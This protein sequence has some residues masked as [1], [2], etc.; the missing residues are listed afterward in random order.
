MYICIGRLAGAVLSGLIFLSLFIHA[1]LYINIHIDMFVLCILLCE[2]LCFVATGTGT[3]DGLP[4]AGE[5]E[6][7]VYKFA[8]LRCDWNWNL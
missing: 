3:C 6:A 4:S 1:C 7:S 5:R 8:V 2:L